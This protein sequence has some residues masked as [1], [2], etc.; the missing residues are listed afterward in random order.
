MFANWIPEALAMIDN[1]ETLPE[2]P[3]SSTI[4]EARKLIVN[5]DASESIP[6]IGTM[7]APGGGVS[8]VF[9]W[10]SATYVLSPGGRFLGSFT[11]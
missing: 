11:R 6:T 5:W 10:T 1:L 8:I 7:E 9:R 2:P 4:T 3:M